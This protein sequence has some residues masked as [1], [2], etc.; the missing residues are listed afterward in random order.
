MLVMIR[1]A[2]LVVL[3]V[4][5][6]G[7]HASDELRE[8]EFADNLRQQP[9]V[10]KIIQLQ[11]ASKPFLAIFTDAEKTDNSNVVILLHEMGESP[12]QKPLT[13]RL[14][15]AL[16]LHNWATLALQLPLREAGA[17]VDEYYPLFDEARGR[18]DAAVEY[19]LKNGAKKIAVMGYGLGASMAAYA[20]NDKAENISALVL[21]SLSTAETSAPQGQSYSFIRNIGLPLLDVY[22]EF[23]LPAVV[24]TARQRRMLG[25][26]NPG[27][28]Q[29]RMDGE[30]HSY[31]QDCELLVKRV[32]SWLT[33]TVSDK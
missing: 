16:P 25:K 21:I 13:H 9:V 22:A 7:V 8:L 5:M 6:C 17:G 1:F 30:D 27:Y 24:D 19:L 2:G 26:D 11:A 20:L 29:V 12:D 4:T 3:L 18:I 31:Q 15:T 32:Y 33:T 10:G 23:D 14:R 28:R